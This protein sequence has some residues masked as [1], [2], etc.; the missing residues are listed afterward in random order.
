[1]ALRRRGEPRDSSV[2][3]LSTAISLVWHVRNRPHVNAVH[4]NR[5]KSLSSIDVQAFMRRGETGNRAPR[6]GNQTCHAVTRCIA[7][8]S[9]NNPLSKSAIRQQ[10]NNR[11]IWQCGAT[12]ERRG[13]N[14]ALPCTRT[15]LFDCQ[16][17]PSL[18]DI[19]LSQSTYTRQAT[20]SP[21][22]VLLRHCT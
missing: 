17:I 3:F 20:A 11:P 19:W 12:F 22:P 4:I 14:R 7:S 15:S 2:T 13:K 9:S 21:L 1:M 18:L 6:R 5:I 16:V 8:T 10:W